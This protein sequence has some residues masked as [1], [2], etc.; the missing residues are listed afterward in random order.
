MS[1]ITAN[2]LENALTGNPEALQVHLTLV[3]RDVS[4][5][6]HLVKIHCHCLSVDGNGRVQ[7]NRLA[8]F[9]RNSIVDYAIPRSKLAEAKARDIR[10]NSTEA[11]AE[12]VERAKR[13]FTDLAKTGEGGEMLLFLLAERFLKLP[14]ILCKMDLKTDSRMHFHGADGVYA[15]VSPEGTLKLFWGESK[16]YSDPNAAIRDCFNSLAPFLIEPE[17]ESA[18][19]ERDLLLL[20][21]KADLSDP[22]LTGALKKYFDKSS[23]MSNRVQ[24]CG[25]ALIG[26]DA[27]FYPQE[28]AKAVAEELVSASRAEL[29]GWCKSIGNRLKLEKLDQ[30]EIEV[31]CLPLPSAEG[32]RDAFLKAMGIK[33]Q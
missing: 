31:F 2:D 11:V 10:F 32:F 9:M 14:Q 25:V 18:A 27:S 5:E 13:S 23:V 21:D 33:T 24:Y 3:E 12:L 7:P 20:S 6:G 30:M 8:E 26:F 19:R 15:D 17:H 4:V 16:I 1:T 22:A 28:N 29:T